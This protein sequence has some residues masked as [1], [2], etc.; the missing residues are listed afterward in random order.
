VADQQ[1]RLGD[2][3]ETA[4]TALDETGAG[5]AQV[6]S[7]H[8]TLRVHIAGAL[9][10]ERVRICL[11]HV[12]AHSSASA[13]E[14]WASLRKV[15][16]PSS[17]RV[18]PSCPAYGACGGCTLM[19]LAYP[20]QLA[21]KR[22]RVLAQFSRFPALATLTVEPCVRSPHLLGYRNQAKYVFGRARDSGQPILGA[23][24]PRSH[25]V[26]DLAGCQVVEPVLDEARQALLTVLTEKAVEPFDEIRRTG[27]LR[28]AVLRATALGQVMVTLVTVRSDWGD[29]KAVAADLCRRC[30]AVTS[31]V[32]NVNESSGNALFGE[33]ESMLVG[34]SSVE[35]TIG[36]VRVRLTAR[37][38][39][40]TNRLV[41]SQI[42]RDLVAAAPDGI[43]RAVDVYAGAC[44]IALSLVAKAS[45]VVAIE[46][47]PAA[48]QAAAAFLAEPGPHEGRVRV[49]TGD[50]AACL[51]EVSDA[52]FVVLNPPRKGCSPEV[53]AAVA[54]LRPKALAYLSCEPRTLAR[55]LA[56][57]VQAGAQVVNVTPF[58]MMPHTPHVETLVLVGFG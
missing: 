25:D 5:L 3:L 52:D 58:D 56:V 46:E 32:L 57:L 20:E 43:S 8:E 7:G 9:P 33:Q 28:Y 12:S 2:E 54:R 22:E 21:W 40:Q 26:V 37:S 44:G 39:F 23:F 55:D 36:D 31:V 29:A 10:G 14:A 45:E 16:A 1:L 6:A 50:A 34:Q 38:F 48:T 30:P 35:D 11:D 51:A 27:L 13:R 53:L 15:L 41:A 17:H 19:A 24:A 42:Y 4:C 49:L 47:N 18:T